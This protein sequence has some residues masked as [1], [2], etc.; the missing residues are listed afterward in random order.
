MARDSADRGRPEILP[1]G[2][3]ETGVIDAPGRSP[4]RVQLI[5]SL[6]PVTGPRQT[7][8]VVLPFTFQATFSGVDRLTVSTDL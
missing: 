1:K 6:F 3:A 7:P 5:L 4:R 8:G 2:A